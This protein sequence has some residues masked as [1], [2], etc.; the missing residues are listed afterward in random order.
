MFVGY[1]LNHATGVYRMWN[2]KTNFVLETRDVTWLKKMFY[3][4]IKPACEIIIR[5]ESNDEVRESTADSAAHEE[6][7]ATEFQGNEADENN[8]EDTIRRPSISPEGNYVTLYGRETRPVERYGDLA[9]M[10]LT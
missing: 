9:A 7:N 8:I 4:N 6:N 1:A 3:Q 10:A 2:P 5:E